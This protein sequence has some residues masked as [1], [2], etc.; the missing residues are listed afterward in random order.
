MG[1][2]NIDYV[3]IGAHLGT[4]QLGFYLL[5]FNLCSWP[6]NMFSA[7]ARRVSLPLFA[8]LHAG[9]TE[10]SA[11]FVPVCT[12]LLLVTLPA[13]LVLAALAEPVVRVVYGDVWLPAAG[14]LPWLM[15]LALVRVD[16]RARL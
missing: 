6:V 15:V 14:V 5:A 1:L 13:C 7:P 12:V 3:V 11:A 8:R 16:R 2:L 10:A 4:V 9:E